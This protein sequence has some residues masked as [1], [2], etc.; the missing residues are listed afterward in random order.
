[1]INYHGYYYYHYY[2]HPYHYLVLL[3]SIV[4]II[5]VFISDSQNLDTFGSPLIVHVQKIVK[6]EL[7]EKSFQYKSIVLKFINA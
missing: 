5:V 1:M 2:F 3:L 7:L 4:M 6:G